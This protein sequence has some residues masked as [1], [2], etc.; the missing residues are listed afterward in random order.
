MLAGASERM[1]RAIQ[2]EVDIPFTRATLL[3]EE[4][5]NGLGPPFLVKA[6]ARIFVVGKDPSEISAA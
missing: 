4:M 1:H 5:E 2:I 6:T 3:K